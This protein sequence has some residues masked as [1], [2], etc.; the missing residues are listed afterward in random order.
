MRSAAC[1]TL[2]NEIAWAKNT[3]ANSWLVTSALSLHAK[4]SM[5]AGFP[6]FLLGGNSDGKAKPVD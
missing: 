6:R 1:L 4:S 2:P 3:V 5:S